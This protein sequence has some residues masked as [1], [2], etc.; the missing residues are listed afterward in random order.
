MSGE[1]DLIIKHQE[2]FS[3]FEEPKPNKTKRNKTTGRL[4]KQSKRTMEHKFEE[5]PLDDDR[6]LRDKDIK[7]TKTKAPK[8]V[9]TVIAS[10]REESCNE[11]INEDQTTEASEHEEGEANSSSRSNSSSSSSSGPESEPGSETE[12]EEERERR[13]R[14]KRRKLRKSKAGKSKPQKSKRKKKLEED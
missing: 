10:S 1:P 2:S 8:E 7:P 5:D 6:L 12:S 11:D 14:R 4:V 13:R 3:E 9:T